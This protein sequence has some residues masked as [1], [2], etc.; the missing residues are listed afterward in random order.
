MR[1]AELAAALPGGWELESWTIGYSDGRADSHPFGRDATGMLLYTPGGCMSAGIA[2]GGRQPL[3]SENT[4]LAPA[5]EKCAAFDTYFHYQGHWH[6]EGDCVVHSVS[7]SLNPNFPGTRQVRT[8]RLEG[9]RLTLSAEDELPGTGV[10]RLHR[11]RWRRSRTER[12]A[13]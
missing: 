2:R 6:V 11:L 13:G 1:D 8:A 5:G 4:R 9:D 7:E 10:R 12:V 3:T